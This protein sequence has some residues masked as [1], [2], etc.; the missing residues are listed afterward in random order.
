MITYTCRIWD[1][2]NPYFNFQVPFH[3]Q[4]FT[5]CC[6]FTAKFMLGPVFFEELTQRSLVTC[7]VYG[8]HYL[9]LLQRNIVPSQKYVNA[10]AEGNADFMQNGTPTHI[11]SCFK[12]VLRKIF[13]E[14][15]VIRCRFSHVWLVRSAGLD[16]SDVL[17]CVYLKQFVSRENVRTLI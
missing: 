16:N 9:S 13:R 5:I 17:F 8:E 1:E 6:E 4:R 11:A 10:L 12:N 7:S 15:H 3:S 2:E 14:N